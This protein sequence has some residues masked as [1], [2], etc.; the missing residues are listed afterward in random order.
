VLG[1]VAFSSFRSIGMI[2]LAGVYHCN[3]VSSTADCFVGFGQ[4]L[5]SRE[6]TRSVGYAGLAQKGTSPNAA[7]AR[8]RVLMGLVS[9]RVSVLLALRRCGS[10]DHMRFVRRMCQLACEVPR[11]CAWAVETL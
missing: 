6:E 9:E 11:G 10:R 1:M 7:T 2:D 5:V 8:L 4:N 3:A